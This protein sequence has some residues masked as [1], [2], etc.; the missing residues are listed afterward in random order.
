MA[1]KTP[2]ESTSRPH[3]GVSDM[4]YK[5]T[6]KRA[7]FLSQF[8]SRRAANKPLQGAAPLTKDDRRIAANK[9]ARLIDSRCQLDKALQTES[10]KDIQKF[11]SDD[12]V[13]RDRLLAKN[14][15][16]EKYEEKHLRN[17]VKARKESKRLYS[18]DPTPQRAGNLDFTEDL[19]RQFKHHLVPSVKSRDSLLQC[20]ERASENPDDNCPLAPNVG[21]SGD[22]DAFK[23]SKP[24]SQDRANKTKVASDKAILENGGKPL[25]VVDGPIENPIKA[26]SP[27]RKLDPGP[28][29]AISEKKQKMSKSEATHVR[30][31]QMAT[32]KLPTPDDTASSVSSNEDSGP[33]KPGK[34][35][36]ADDLTS[37]AKRSQPIVKPNKEGN[38]DDNAGKGKGKIGTLPTIEPWYMGH[39]RA[40]MEP[41]FNDCVFYRPRKKQRRGPVKDYSVCGA[42]VINAELLTPPPSASS[43]S[44]E[45]PKQSH[46]HNRGKHPHG[47]DNKHRHRKGRNFRGGR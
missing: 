11:S 42:L 9:T 23:P 18:R 37:E 1:K 15:R 35:G 46:G 3:K 40:M 28:P 8:K 41:D 25:P 12:R 7:S 32:S 31:Q 13:E 21:Q 36:A 19:L 2:S 44:S 39:A 34:S 14:A 17:L 30:A 6:T 22:R 27:K 29:L 38:K 33:G 20:L 16:L 10:A 45:G 5:S 26:Q 4:R 47:R 24:V 43:S